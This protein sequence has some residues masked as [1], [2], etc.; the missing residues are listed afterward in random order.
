MSEI[1]QTVEWLDVPGRQPESQAPISIADFVE[2]LKEMQSSIL[3]AIDGGK[4]GFRKE[5]SDGWDKAVYQVIVK[6]KKPPV[7]VSYPLHGVPIPP[8][9]MPK[10][11]RSDNRTIM[12]LGMEK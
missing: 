1:D 8:A 10:G 12:N 11:L 3:S 2:F 4:V 7:E 9:D 5:Y 6:Q